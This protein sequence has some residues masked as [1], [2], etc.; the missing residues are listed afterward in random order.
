MKLALLAVILMASLTAFAAPTDNGTYALV[1]YLCDDPD[2]Y[3]PDTTLTCFKLV[4]RC[5]VSAGV[6][7][8]GATNTDADIEIRE[9]LPV[10]PYR[11]AVL[12]F[13]GEKGTQ[14]Y[15]ID[16]TH[17]FA[18]ATVAT[19]RANG[20]KTYEARWLDDSGNN[21]GDGW[22]SGVEGLGPKLATCG[23]REV[24][25]WI[26][27]NKAVNVPLC[28]TG[29]SFGGVQ[30][31]YAIAAHDAGPYLKS[32]V[33]SAGPSVVDIPRGCFN[34]TYDNGLLSGT[35]SLTIGF[36][37]D[38]PTGSLRTDIIDRLMGWTTDPN[39]NCGTDAVHP[40]P[41]ST[42]NTPAAQAMA[43]VSYGSLAEARNYAPSTRQFFVEAELDSTG[44]T[45]QGGH[46]YTQVT[47]HKGLAV[48]SQIHQDALGPNDFNTHTLFN[49][50][51]GSRL[52]QAYLLDPA[53]CQ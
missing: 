27:E 53:N 40:T 6:D 14:Y 29:N 35:Q 9:R 26:Q 24:I 3:G 45:V 30:I 39:N 20:Y 51:T 16:D 11:G 34:Q 52:I 44:A 1:P 22:L 25:E 38:S 31:A 18:G 46:Y 7:R 23:A 28:A 5:A 17:E 15:D 4:I 42:Y 47:G 32:A 19:L 12:F 48:I 21:F 10:P 36:K 8:Y 49:T 13:S 2:L 37:L 43:L 33:Y 41:A 50:V